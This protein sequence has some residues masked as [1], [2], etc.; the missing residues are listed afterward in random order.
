MT[1]LRGLDFRPLRA[2]A[3][4]HKI[5]DFSME[6]LIIEQRRE[7]QNLSRKLTSNTKNSATRFAEF[8]ADGNQE[9]DFEVRASN[10]GLCPLQSSC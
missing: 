6:R 10:V 7:R 8:D 1:S 3:R 9:L 2:L 5:G 4:E